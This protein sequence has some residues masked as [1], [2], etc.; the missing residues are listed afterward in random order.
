MLDAGEIA[1]RLKAIRHL[2]VV[3]TR[4]PGPFFFWVKLSAR[5]G[6]AARRAT[7]GR[8]LP[9]VGGYRP[10]GTPDGGELCDRH[11]AISGVGHSKE[12]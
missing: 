5:P 11:R 12:R 7:R 6:L 3:S 2:I 4:D 1:D 8:F 10:L 9:V